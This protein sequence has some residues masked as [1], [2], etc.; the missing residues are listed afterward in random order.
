MAKTPDVVEFVR[1]LEIVDHVPSSAVSNDDEQGFVDSGSLVSFTINLQGQDKEDV[2]NS[3]LLAQLAA[4][5]KYDRQKNTE[6]W[7]QLYVYVLEK[8]GWVIQSFSFEEYKSGSATF[9]M[10]KAVLQLLA[11]VASGSEVA[12][13][14]KTIEALEKLPADD[15]RVEVLDTHSC[16]SNAGN[17]QIMPCDVDKSGQVNMVLGAFHFTTKQRVRNRFLFFEFNSASTRM[18]NG[19]QTVTLNQKMYGKVRDVVIEKLGDRAKKFIL[20]VSI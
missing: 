11:A 18:Y 15:G 10:D 7:Y 2:L 8:I 6:K 16:T 1:N 5:K 20:D 19:A 17:F 9:T 13:M 12:I 14:K 4:S 3:T